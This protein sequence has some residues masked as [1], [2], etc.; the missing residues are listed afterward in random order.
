MRTFTNRHRATGKLKAWLALAGIS[1]AIVA[2][3][4]C[5]D[6][7]VSSS[8]AANDANKSVVSNFIEEFKNSANMDIVDELFSPEFVHHIPDPRLPP[9][10][11]GLKL[12]G[13]AIVGGFPDVQVTVE[14]LLA[15]GDKVIERTTAKA[16]H[17]GEFN[18]IPP[19]GKPVVW[20]EIHIYRLENG[21][22]VELWSEINL[23]GLL[24][25]LGAIPSP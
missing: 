20:T 16:T 10:R 15:D 23:L 25:Q 12:A 17:T 9:G 7:G 22:I 19:T 6:D 1:I 11:E 4:A 14:D 21:K 5:G 24:V 2:L 13:Q 3:A 18:G 8:E